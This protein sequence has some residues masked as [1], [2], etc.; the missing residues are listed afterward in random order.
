MVLDRFSVDSGFQT[1][2]RVLGGGCLVGLAK[3]LLVLPIEG[4]FLL[5][6]CP[7]TLPGPGTAWVEKIDSAGE[8]SPVL[9]LPLG[10]AGSRKLHFLRQPALAAGS[11]HL[12]LGTWD[13]PCIAEIDG[14]GEVVG[15]RCLPDYLRPGTP[16]KER[17][18][19]ERR[20]RR[21]TQ[22][23]LLPME[24]PDHL[25]WYDRIFVTSRGLV[26][27]RLRGMEDRDL[28]LLP[29]EGGSF[30]TDYLF[31][32]NTFV[33][34][35]SILTVEDLLQGTRVRIFRNPWQ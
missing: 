2:R 4:L 12:F 7:A 33:G 21:I 6:V 19:L 35:R 9:S 22:L 14:R 25:P 5:R 23:G 29:V 18:D 1:R 13:T 28:V 32:E 17:S 27:R 16:A 8:L 3:R 15:H 31:P 26:V 11:D 10:R 20:F 34:N 24:V 30:V